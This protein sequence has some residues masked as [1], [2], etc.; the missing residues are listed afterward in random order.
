[1]DIIKN[2]AVKVLGMTDEEVQSLYKKTDD[3]QEVLVENALDLLVN[4]D[5]QRLE[6]IVNTHKE[7]LTNIHDKGYKKAQK[8]V[9]SAFEQQVKEK[10]G[11]QTDKMGLELIDDLITLNKGKG[12]EDIKTHP[13]YLKLERMLQNEYVP[14]SKL[15]EIEAQ[16]G[17]FKTGIEKQ[18]VRNVIVNDALSI[19][20]SLN[21][22]LPQDA[23]KASNL[24]QL[25]LKEIENGFDFQL[26]EGGNHLILKD[27]KRLETSNMNPVAFGD[28][29]K[30]KASELFDFAA[31]GAKGGTGTGNQGVGSQGVSLLKDRE[32]F[33]KKYNDPSIDPDT[34]MKIF[35]QAKKQGIIQ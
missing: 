35:E 17:E 14:K 10:Y 4:R 6:R 8:E 24:K 32:D 30:E 34:R 18:K 12:N 5:K 11:Y 3:G 1:M 16:F 2:L 26:Q 23:K 19:L 29:V 22:V 15:E 9:L 33:Y 20:D 31:Q 21:P 25:F 27:G 13:D 28:F 7:E